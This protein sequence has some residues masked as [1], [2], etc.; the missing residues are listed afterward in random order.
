VKL[1]AAPCERGD[2]PPE[3]KMYKRTVTAEVFFIG[4]Y[5]LN[6]IKYNFRPKESK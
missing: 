2:F 1:L 5:S 4:V 6:F 3:N